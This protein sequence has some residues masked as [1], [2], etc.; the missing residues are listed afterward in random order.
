MDLESLSKQLDRLGKK[1]STLRVVAADQGARVTDQCQ[2][3]DVCA[4]EE[5]SLYD[6]EEDKFEKAICLRI[7]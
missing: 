4:V 6:A 3:G 2:V 5:V 1:R 7:Q